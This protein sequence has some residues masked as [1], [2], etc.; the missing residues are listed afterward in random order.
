MDDQKLTEMQAQTFYDF[1]RKEVNM[2]IKK[3]NYMSNK[4][5]E[6]YITDSPAAKMNRVREMTYKTT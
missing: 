1:L 3:Y 4:I 6:G 2:S 5:G